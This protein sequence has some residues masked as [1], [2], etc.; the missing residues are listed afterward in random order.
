MM[1]YQ[2]CGRKPLWKVKA[3]ITVFAWKNWGKQRENSFSIVDVVDKI[4]TG[5][6]PNTSQTRYC[7]SHIV[8][9]RSVE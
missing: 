3:T 8:S 1:N 7:L 9:I 6:L 5:R 4:R 2:G